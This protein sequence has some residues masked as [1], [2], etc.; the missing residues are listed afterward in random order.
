MKGTL[1]CLK[2]CFS[3]SRHN[4]L[5]APL[6]ERIKR[7]STTAVRCLQ[8]NLPSSS[9]P[10]C[11]PSIAHATAVVVVVD[12]IVAWPLH[13]RNHHHCLQPLHAQ[14]CWSG[15]HPLSFPPT[16][17]RTDRGD[18]GP[19]RLTMGSSRPVVCHPR[20]RTMPQSGL[21]W[22]TSPR[23]QVIR[24]RRREKKKK[25]K[26]TESQWSLALFKCY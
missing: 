2:D 11:T 3:N 25:T 24:G 16:G 15:P 18:L 12:T 5:S 20:L 9:L 14:G 21:H 26:P 8:G 1:D 13:Q 10:C 23:H 4:M 7:R 17:R 22:C 19:R 6:Y